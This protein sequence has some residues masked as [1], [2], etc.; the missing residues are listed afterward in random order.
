[1]ALRANTI[2]LGARWQAISTMAGEAWKKLSELE[3]KPYQEKYEAAKSQ[4]DKDMKAF[5]DA[6]NEK[7]KGDISDLV[8]CG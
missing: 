1:M 7:S 3:K 8:T 5:L 4:F 2:K 6:G